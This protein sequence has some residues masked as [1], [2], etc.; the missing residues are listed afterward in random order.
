M[1]KKR[2]PEIDKALIGINPFI[3]NELIKVR[4]FKKKQEMNLSSYD[5]NQTLNASIEEKVL[6]EYETNTKLFHDTEYRNIILKL[7][8]NA[9]K[10]FLFISYEVK[11]NEDYLWINSSLFMKTTTLS[12]K[13]FT[14][15]VDDLIRYG[16]ITYTKYPEVYFINPLIFFSGDRLK[17]YPDN[18]KE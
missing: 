13:D 11:T 14:K 2:K 18:L 12:K 10:L 16:I 4:S 7:N 1:N 17:K 15:A 9:L 6:I 8:G 3:V 5:K